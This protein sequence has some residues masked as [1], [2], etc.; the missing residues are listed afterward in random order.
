MKIRWQ[1]FPNCEKKKTLAAKSR[2]V[3]CN[4]SN[5]ML[6]PRYHIHS[7]QKCLT[8]DAQLRPTNYLHDGQIL[9]SLKR[10]P[11]NS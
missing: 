2:T 1:G 11:E 6:S 3:N 7:H 8:V 9:Q 10:V 4:K 5:K